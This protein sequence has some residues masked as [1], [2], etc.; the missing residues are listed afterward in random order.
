MTIFK[1]RGVA[2][3]VLV[4]CIALSVMIGGAKGSKTGKLG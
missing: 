2:W 1:K 4:L 3:A